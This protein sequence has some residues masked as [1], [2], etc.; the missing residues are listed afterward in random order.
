MIIISLLWGWAYMSGHDFIVIGAG[1]AGAA[2]TYYASSR[3]YRVRVYD[4]HTPGAKPCGWAV[5]LQIEKYIKIPRE[6]I[7]TEIR[8]FRIFLD[9]KMVREERGE[10]W[11]Y[12]VDKPGLLNYLIESAELVKKPIV[13]NQSSLRPLRKNDYSDPRSTIIAVGGIGAPRLGTDYINA[14]QQIVKVKK[15]IDTDIIE[16]WFDSNLVGYYWVFPRDTHVADIGVGGYGSFEEFKRRL[17]IFVKKRFRDPEPL[18]PIRGARINIGGVNTSLFVRDEFPVIGEAAGFVYPIT[19]EGIRPSIASAFALFNK[20]E[21]GADPLK[22]IS[23]VIT[24]INRQRKL[25]QK[26]IE[27]RPST[28]AAVLESLP[29]SLFTSIGLGEL[30]LKSAVKLLL[31]LPRGAVKVLQVLLRD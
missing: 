8:G 23:N 28:R 26:I 5:P 1:P 20:I 31:S 22:T 19:G 3:G 9:E 4:L 17:A 6:Y 13:L 30:D 7:L 12:I 14:V 24:W 15:P 2:F 18:S 21:K 11:G 29:T 27:S 25:L 16:I 10:L